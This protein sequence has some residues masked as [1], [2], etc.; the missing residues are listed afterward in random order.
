MNNI[1][2]AFCVEFIKTRKSKILLTTILIFTIIPLMMGLIIFVARNPEIAG[3]LGMIGMKAKMFG[4]NDWPGYF[5]ILN[6]TM[7]S[8]GLIGFG[9]VTSWV[10]GREHIDRTMK[11]ILALPVRRSSIVFA[12]IIIVFIWCILLALVLYS[13]G[14]ISGLIMHLPGWT[15]DNFWHFSNRFFMTS[16]LTLLLCSP[17]SYLAGYS[18]GIIAPLGFVILTMIMAQFIGLIGLGPYFPWAIP[19]LFSVAKDTQGMQLHITS[20]VILALTFATGYWATLHWW[21]HADHH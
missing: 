2:A 12:K 10:F 1:T 8:V 6:Q 16:L 7:G 15:A 20:Y 3:K 14:I 13:V 5:A 17:V 9:F 11:D 4:E 18:R 21:L 19:G